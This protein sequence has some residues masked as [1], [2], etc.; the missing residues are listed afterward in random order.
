MD[1]LSAGLGV[2]DEA[3]DCCDG[4][5]YGI[6]E[7]EKCGVEGCSQKVTLIRICRRLEGSVLQSR[8][9]ISK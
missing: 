1:R 9:C 2:F 4:G 8:C 3:G 5:V 7:V 6:P